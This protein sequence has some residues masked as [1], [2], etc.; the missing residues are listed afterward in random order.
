MTGE[1]HVAPT[2][3]DQAD[4][5]E[6][7][8]FQTISRAAW[9]AQPGDTV[10][11]HGGEYREW[12]QPRHAGSAIPGGSPTSR[13]RGA[14]RGQGFRAGDWLGERRGTVWRVGVPNDVFGSFNP[15]AEEINGDWIVYKDRRTPKKH[16]GDVYLNGTSFYEVAFGDDVAD[17]PL[18][19]KMIDDWT[20]SP[21]PGP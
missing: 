10:V 5:S 14:R 11:V 6:Q 12:V 3:S 18:R 8:P 16:L 21:R 15:F 19:T 20:G 7:Q 13:R 17:P 2:G 4:G 9:L 1:L